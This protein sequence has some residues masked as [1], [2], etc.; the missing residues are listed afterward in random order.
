[1]LEWSELSTTTANTKKTNKLCR[2]VNTF[3][4]KKGR[5]RTPAVSWFLVF[6]F[7]TKYFNHFE[8]KNF[9]C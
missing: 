3:V 8:M 9:D 7:L 5:N 6:I 2:V 1:M 4:G